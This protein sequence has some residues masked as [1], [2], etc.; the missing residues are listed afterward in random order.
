MKRII[1][2]A[3]GFVLTAG[4]FASCD[5][6]T[7]DPITPSNTDTTTNKT[8]DT[9]DTPPEPEPVVI[10]TYKV[11]AKLTA[12]IDFAPENLTVTV[13]KDTLLTLAADEDGVYVARLYAGKYDV[14]VSGKTSANGKVYSLSGTIADLEITENYDTT[15]VWEIALASV[16]KNQIII[17]EIYCG[18]STYHDATED[19]DVVLQKDK[20]IKLYNNSDQPAEIKNFCF[21]ICYPYLSNNTPGQ[22][23]FAAY[24]AEGWTPA[25]Q[26]IWWIDEI[27]FEPF[28]EKVFVIYSADDYTT[29]GGVN[30][31]NDQYYCLIDMTSAFFNASYYTEPSAGKVKFNV[32]T[33]AQGN[34][35]QIG[36]APALFIFTT[37]ETSPADF[38]ADANNQ[39]NLTNADWGK[40]GSS[41]KIPNQNIIDGVDIKNATCT[42]KKDGSLNNDLS[43]KYAQ[44]LP[45]AVDKGFVNQTETGKGFSYYRN[46]DKETTEALPENKDK[47]AYGYT[48]GTEDVTNGESTAAGSTDPSGINAQASLKNGAHIIYKDTD[49]STDDFHQRKQASLKD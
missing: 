7:D 6:D 30:L 42:Y 39:I 29:L 44:R 3:L 38:A 8:P 15:K 49:N 17:T 23:A 21:G 34:A 27:K 25:T 24:S 12:D 28:E 14:E 31:D 26:G 47:I 16:E 22:I 11:S 43:T 5:D 32:V 35:W 45:N 2:L 9:P 1:Y 46:V 18:N 19:K 20:Y 40:L 48:L 37:G 13:S 4:V 10:P 41:L 33:L 36:N